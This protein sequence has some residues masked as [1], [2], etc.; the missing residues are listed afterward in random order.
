MRPFSE[1]TFR[2][3]TGHYFG[4]ASDCPGRITVPFKPLAFCTA[5]AVV[6]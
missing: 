1:I 4:I 3:A 2:I 5:L 6:P